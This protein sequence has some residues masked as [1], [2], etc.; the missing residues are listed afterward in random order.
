MCVYVFLND[1]EIKFFFFS[2][3]SILKNSRKAVFPSVS[4]KKTNKK[5]FLQNCS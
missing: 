4:D 1:F 5:F 3:K 2:V